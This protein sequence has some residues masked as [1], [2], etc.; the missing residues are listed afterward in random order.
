MRERTENVELLHSCYIRRDRAFLEEKIMLFSEAEKPGIWIT[1][2]I[3][4]ASL[5]IDFDMLYTEMC[6]ADRFFA[7]NG[8][9]A[10]EKD[11]IFLKNQIL[12]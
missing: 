3:V 6:T 1:T 5:D 4:E 10:T 7:R 12:L 8:T 11:D 9:N 2:Q